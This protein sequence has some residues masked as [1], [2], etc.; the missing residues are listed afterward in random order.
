[1]VLAVSVAIF[2]CDGATSSLTS[3]MDGKSVGTALREANDEI[4]KE[5]GFEKGSKNSQFL[6]FGWTSERLRELKAEA[7]KSEIPSEKIG[8]EGGSER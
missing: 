7:V 1:M 6:S 5:M 8:G 2:G 4:V 3:P